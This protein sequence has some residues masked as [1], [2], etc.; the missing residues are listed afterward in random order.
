MNHF[1]PF[2]ILHLVRPEVVRVHLQS[3]PG[4]KSVH[5]WSGKGRFDPAPQPDV[6]LNHSGRRLD[7][8][9]RAETV[10]FVNRAACHGLNKGVNIPPKNPAVAFGSGHGRCLQ[11]R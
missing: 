10:S 3:G 1:S 5:R 2:G 8:P 7:P 6:D 9:N 11:G 4:R